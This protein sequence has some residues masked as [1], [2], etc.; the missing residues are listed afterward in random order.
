MKLKNISIL[1]IFAISFFVGS[2]LFL[3]N[4]Y[5]SHSLVKTNNSPNSVIKAVVRVLD[6][7]TIETTDG[8][9]VRL[10]GIDSPEIKNENNITECFAE[11]AKNRLESLVLGKEVSLVKDISETDDYGR[12][13][14]YVYSDSTL[15]NSLMVQEGYA[16][17]STFPPDTKY[18]SLLRSAQKVAQKNNA[19]L[20]D[21]CK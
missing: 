14:R 18:T 3:L 11:E 12:L 6:G 17:S 8:I 16:V 13:L 10:I 2:Y 7:D 19:G 5:F 1:K 21:K 9:K 20:W 15:V 4:F